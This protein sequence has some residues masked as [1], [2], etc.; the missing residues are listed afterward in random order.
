MSLLMV[1]PALLP[2]PP[3]EK[4]A[5]SDTPPQAT[6]IHLRSHK[7]PKDDSILQ[8]PQSTEAASQRW[9]E[10]TPAQL[11]SPQQGSYVLTSGQAVNPNVACQTCIWTYIFLY[12]SIRGKY[13]ELSLLLFVSLYFFK[14]P[15]LIN[16]CLLKSC[17]FGFLDV[18]AHSTLCHTHDNDDTCVGSKT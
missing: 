14:M 6:L 2:P 16:Y 5:S 15:L 8:F 3:K 9:L 11:R 7:H 17:L 10:E 4:T 1:P 12:S 18:W 13:F